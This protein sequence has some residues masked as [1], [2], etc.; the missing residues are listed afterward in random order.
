MIKHLL[1]SSLALAAAT[2]AASAQEACSSY[3][4]QRGD[5]LRELAIEVYATEDF[6]IIFDANRDVIGSNPNIIRVGDVLE[7]PCLED[8]GRAP[9]LA[10]TEAERLAAEMA[11]ELVKAAEERAEKAV[12]EAEARVAAAEA[13]AKNAS[14]EAVV[15][16]RA[17]AKEEIE[18]AR[19]EAAALIRNAGTGERPEI[20]DRQLLLITGGNYAPFT[21]ESL[22][23]R[24][25]YT[26][27]VETAMFRA[28]PEQA[29]KIQFVNDWSSHLDLLMPT[30]AFDATFPWSRP[31]CEEAVALSEDDRNRCETYNFSNPFYEVV[32]T[33]FAREGSGYEETLTYA[34]F[35]GATICRPEG[36]S[37]SHMDAVSLYEP[38]IKLLRPTSPD[39]CFHALMEGTA[40]IVAIEAHLAAE[41][42]ERLGYKHRIIENP[43][44]AA[45]K[46][47]NVMT[48]KD[49]PDGEAILETLNQGLAIMQ[50][51]G[52]WRDI[53][54]TALRHQMENG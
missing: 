54:S 51:S 47:L 21:D 42:I 23:N 22:P 8:V 43:N 7:L 39:D 4:I 1:I 30:L 41:A 10:D 53:V 2:G 24:G 16:A 38:V 18:A 15:A 35:A 9:A 17:A 50:Q 5:S 13:E 31:N 44:L 12:A 40:D 11:A 28:A 34:D 48:H 26:H 6:R 33:F 20:R 49:N 29:Y 27:L 3:E 45:I 14:E 36:W 25:L 52:E 37:L 19:A 46:S 32:D